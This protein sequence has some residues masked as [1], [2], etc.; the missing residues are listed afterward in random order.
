MG[1][2]DRLLAVVI[3]LVLTGCAGNRYLERTADG[4]KA[5]REGEYKRALEISEEIIGE[6]EGKGRIASPSIYSLSGISAYRLEDYGKSLEYLEKANQQ[7]YSDPEMVS[8][9]AGNYRYIDNLSKEISALETYLEKYPGAADHRRLRERLFQTCLESEDFELAEDLW[10][11]MDS[12]SRNEIK[13]LE[14]YLKINRLKENTEICDSLAGRILERGET[15]NE[16]ALSWF[17]ESYFWRAENEYLS[18][19]KAYRDNRTHK[20]YEILLKAFRQVNADFRKSRD[21]FLKLYRLYPNPEYAEYLGNIFT[22]L[23]DREKA[24]YYKA[25]AN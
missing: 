22:R 20:Q 6:V 10:N 18:Q 19:M 11:G 7:G 21:L 9:L 16:S 13:N 4:E 25:R 17:A 12:L 5:Y 14:T 8:C 2:N 24:R 3:C 15:E 23:E 1:K